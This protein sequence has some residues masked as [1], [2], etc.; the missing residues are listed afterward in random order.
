[1]ES[2][3]AHSMDADPLVSIIMAVRNGAE[4][5]EEAIASVLVQG[6]RNWEL[7]IVDNG[8]TD[9]TQQLVARNE[10][11]RIRL[12]HEPITGV[13]R[14]RNM[15][16]RAMR[17]EYFCFLDADDR[18]PPESIAA[19]VAVLIADPTVHFVDGR[20]V[21][22]D[23]DSGRV[24]SDRA[25]YFEGMPREALLDISAACFFGLTWMIRRVPGYAYAFHEHMTNS[26]DH[27][28]YL[29]IADQGRYT[30][31]NTPVLEYRKGRGS[32]TAFTPDVQQGYRELYRYM[33]G[34]HPAPTAE[35]LNK[36]WNIVRSILFRSYLKEGKPWAALK[37]W[38]ER[39]P[40]S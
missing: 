19:R 21:T 17:G 13:S 28:F 7:L 25:P 12:F 10:D 39:P 24:L 33:A 2:N 29:S 26:E 22:F 15:A 4:T 16:L 3:K 38:V 8:S 36:V 34:M 18:L 27:V 37:A 14:A 20:I 32:A 6:W 9:A 40:R 23:H 31:V 35:Q 11:P 1:M 30:F 5:I